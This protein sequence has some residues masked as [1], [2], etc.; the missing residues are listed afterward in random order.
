MCDRVELDGPRLPRR[1]AG[2]S[3]LVAMVTRSPRSPADPR[4]GRAVLVRLTAVLLLPLVLAPSSGPTGAGA[5]GGPAGGGGLAA[6]R[7]PGFGVGSRARPR[8]RTAPPPS[9]R[10]IARH[11]HDAGAFTQG[12][13]FDGGRLYES[14]GR[15]GQSELRRVDLATGRVLQRRKLSPRDFGEG[16][17]SHSGR[18]IQL[19]WRNQTGYVYERDS[20]RPIGRFA[21]PTEGWGITTDGRELIMSDGSS[22]LRFLDPATFAVRRRLAV[23]SGGMPVTGLNELEHLPGGVVLANVWPTSRLVRIDLASGRVTASYD[24]SRLNAGFD[25]VANGTA[26]EPG[27][28]RLYLTGKNWPVLY[29]VTLPAPR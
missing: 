5:A 19:T 22:E 21:Y 27:T 7:E 29:Q 20:F 28:G 17:T 4:A 25:G 6:G 11:P 26:Y 12:L 13:M 3:T 23:T 18:L 1:R 14:T 10:V 16:L 2:S 24:L 9:P 15:Y 8:S